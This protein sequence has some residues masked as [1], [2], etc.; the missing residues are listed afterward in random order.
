MPALRNLRLNGWPAALNAHE[1]LSIS[2]A[3]LG[4]EYIVRFHLPVFTDP[5][6]K[7]YL[8]DE[9]FHYREGNIY[10]FNHGCYHAAANSSETRVSLYLVLDAFLDRALF[11]R[12]LPG[13][14][15]PDYGFVKERTPDARRILSLPELRP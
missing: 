10:F 4:S 6:A 2:P 13:A 5:D 8:D 9:S 11:A 15:S 7:V 3:R 1:E 14:N 12:H